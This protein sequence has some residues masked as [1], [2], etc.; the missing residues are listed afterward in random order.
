MNLINN[1]NLFNNI[2]YS[3]QSDIPKNDHYLK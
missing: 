1:N 2:L 3:Y